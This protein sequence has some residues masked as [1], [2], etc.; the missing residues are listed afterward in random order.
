MGVL[1]FI[2]WSIRLLR[3]QRG[4]AGEEFTPEELA[5]LGETDESAEGTGE[6]QETESTTEGEGTEAESET[7]QTT[8]AEGAEE[9]TATEEA[10]TVPQ[11]RFDKVYG[12]SKESQ[13]K[14]DL[15]TRLGREEYYKVY[16]DE[17]PHGADDL[18]RMG[19]KY[20][21]VTRF[22]DAQS[23]VIEGG[24][25]AG[26]T[27]GEV[28]KTDPMAAQDMY[29]DYRDDQ[30]SASDKRA[31]D[32]SVQKTAVETELTDF[33]AGIAKEM[34][35]KESDALSTEEGTK[36]DGVVQTV[37]DWMEKS[38][39]F[40]YKLEDA[41]LIMNKDDLLAG[42]KSD[43]AKALVAQLKAGS[44]PAIQA[45]KG[46]AGRPSGYAAYE[47]MDRNELASKIESMTDAQ[48]TT[49]SKDAPQSIKDKF[50][51]IP[52]V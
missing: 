49:F 44:T 23:M 19:P 11:D 39:R 8:E 40:N 43:G 24:Q 31:T 10:G 12:E 33:S 48:F 16:P 46:S 32:A 37:I 4:E 34:F 9:T 26:M 14:L 25:Y 6:T 27:L 29:L 5:I 18:A 45:N 50:S 41:Y 17:K 28:Y 35:E 20:D 38:G 30:R 2:R 13:R 15:M 51:E 42:A 1:N 36:V 3:D 22:S 7:E 21:R 47:S 52:W